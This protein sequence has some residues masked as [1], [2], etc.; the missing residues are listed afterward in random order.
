VSERGVANRGV[1]S[2]CG[3]GRAQDGLLRVGKAVV[4]AGNSG[5][6]LTDV[7]PPDGT[8]VV[9]WQPR[10][11]RPPTRAAWPVVAAWL[12]LERT[13]QCAQSRQ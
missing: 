1:D 4:A 3:R 5:H 2:I 7:R 12:A 13:A 6:L 9:H 11:A 10:P 8:V